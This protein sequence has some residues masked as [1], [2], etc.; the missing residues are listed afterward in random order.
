MKIVEVKKET[1]EI[2]SEDWQKMYELAE[3]FRKICD[4][5]GSCTIDCPM[6]KFCD[7]HSESPKE[8]LY[9]LIKFLDDN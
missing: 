7:N 4:Y 3:D 1:I 2:T 5:D 9:D 6:Y 8:Y